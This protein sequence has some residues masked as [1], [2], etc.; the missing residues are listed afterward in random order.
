ME[1]YTKV[2]LIT[3]L[4]QIKSMGW[5][6]NARAGNCGGVGNT[7]ED[8]LGIA[9]NNLPLPNA[10]EWELKC[11]RLKSSALVTLFHMEPS[12]TALRFVPK[13][14]LPVYG[15][16][17]K[18]AGAKYTANEKSF[19]QTIS[20]RD[21]SDR[22]FTVIVDRTQEKV[23]IS[24]DKDGVSDKHQDWL[25]QIIRD[26]PRYELDPAPYWGF[27]DLYHKAG[28]KLYNC[29][30]VEAKCK[31]EAGKEFF[32]YEKIRMLS[33]FSLERF[34]AAIEAGN[35]LID[36]DARTGHNHGTKFRYRHNCF[37]DLYQ[38]VQEIN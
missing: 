6:A 38:H 5:I 37:Q 25:S 11:R 36:F 13:V 8:L 18:Q 9:E 1:T 12:P 29:F 15:W 32:K 20:T 35:I 30:F 21:H 22:G 31:K 3:K 33:G 24:F 23:S 34:I 7:L 10:A 28:T 17:H 26:H 16:P 14:L 4:I 2:T 19:R 27:T